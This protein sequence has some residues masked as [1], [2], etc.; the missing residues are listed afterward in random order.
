MTTRE[1]AGDGSELRPMAGWHFIYR[2]VLGTEHDGARWDIDV[3]FFDWDDKV[4]LYRDGRQDRV[5]R[6]RTRFPL[7]DGARIEAAMSTFGLRR[8]H[9]VL[10]DGTER[11][12]VPARGTG[13][14]WR[15]DLDRD[16]PT[17]SR[18]LGAASTAVLVIALVLQLPQLVAAVAELTG[19][20]TFVAPV[21][22]PGVLNTPLTIAA[23]LA[24][25]ERALRLRHHWLID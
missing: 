5:Q 10:P 6:G 9:L 25:L 3:D 11:P 15:A 24:A 8:A 17:I 20:F 2:S 21:T 14:R 12:L 23:V 22:L 4:V 16:H 7:D 18:R 19:W 1:R 13:E